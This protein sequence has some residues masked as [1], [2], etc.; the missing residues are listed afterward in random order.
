LEKIK[1]VVEMLLPP[2]IPV[3][4]DGIGKEKL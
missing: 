4:Q 3:M 1:A 2:E